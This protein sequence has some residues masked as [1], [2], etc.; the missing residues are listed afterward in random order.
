MLRA[1]EPELDKKYPDL[2]ADIET[3]AD[4]GALPGARQSQQQW[5]YVLLNA[6]TAI[7][8]ENNFTKLLEDVRKSHCLTKQSPVGRMRLPME[9]YRIAFIC[10]ATI[11]AKGD[12]LIRGR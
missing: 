5:A 7:S 3:N 2:F 8:S 1:L 12:G 6:A 9:N 10:R 4:S 11:F